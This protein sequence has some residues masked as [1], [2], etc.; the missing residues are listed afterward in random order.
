ML[1]RALIGSSLRGPGWDEPGLEEE[2]DVFSD[3]FFQGLFF[4]QKSRKILPKMSDFVR[5]QNGS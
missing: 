5:G 3:F 2:E 1:E 4:F